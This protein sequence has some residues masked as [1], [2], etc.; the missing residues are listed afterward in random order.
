MKERTYTEKEIFEH[1]DHWRNILVEGA[2]CSRKKDYDKHVCCGQDGA[3]IS[4]TKRSFEALILELKQ[5]FMTPQGFRKAIEEAGLVGFRFP[6]MPS[7][8]HKKGCD[9]LLFNHPDFNKLQCKCG[10]SCGYF[11]DKCSQNVQNASLEEKK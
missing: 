1:I 4:F 9:V 11:C 2:W 3:D 5:R 10:D 8:Q 7:V 6:D